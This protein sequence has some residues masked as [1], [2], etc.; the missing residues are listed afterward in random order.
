MRQDAGA[1]RR[2]VWRISWC[3]ELEGLAGSAPMLASDIVV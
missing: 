2:V 1:A 3:I